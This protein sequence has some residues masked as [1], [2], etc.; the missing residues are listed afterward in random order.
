MQINTSDDLLAA[1]EAARVASGKSERELAL[2][3]GKSH[4]AYWWWKKKA[5][6]VSV[7]TALEY[8]NALG[9]QLLV[10]PKEKAPE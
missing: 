10:E 1:M 5:G 4:S 2:S 6:V 3:T 8:A 9:L 7:N